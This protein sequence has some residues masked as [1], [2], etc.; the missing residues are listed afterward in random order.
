MGRT[1]KDNTE[2]LSKATDQPTFSSRVKKLLGGE[3]APVEQ[4]PITKPPVE[5]EMIIPELREE[6]APEPEVIQE[7][8]E[9]STPK[10][11]PNRERLGLVRP[12]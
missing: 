4:K 11:F 3:P 9:V 5:P 6:I 12:A 2:N 8:Q 7:V 1:K 10:R